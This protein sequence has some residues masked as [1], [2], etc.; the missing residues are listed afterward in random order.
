[1]NM[2]PELLFA[3][4]AKTV[5][6]ALHRNIL[7]VGSLA[8]AY[9]HRDRL[10][11]QVVATKDADVI[12]QPAGAV[13][14]CAEIAARLLAADWQRTEQCYPQAAADP[15]STL[16]AIRLKPRDVDAFFI[17]L[18]GLPQV[19]QNELKLWVPCQLDDGWYGIPCF[20]FMVLL[21]HDRRDTELGIQHASPPLMALANLLSH[22]TLGTARMEGEIEGR[23]ILRSAK[24]LGRVLALAWLEPND[25]E[26]WLP[27]WRNAL[28][29]CFRDDSAALAASAGSGLRSLLADDAALEEAHFTTSV[30]LLRGHSVTTERL[31]IAGERLLIDVIDPIA[32]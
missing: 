28:Q 10:T 21:A 19:G 31:R 17:E 16:R 20:K 24:D 1:M 26:T 2:D 32:R 18:L 12:V 14:E 30:G 5:P 8:A 6:K 3:M 22:P 15:Q 27:I 7:V 11:G 13:S 9:N 29:T 4:V 23:K 25:L